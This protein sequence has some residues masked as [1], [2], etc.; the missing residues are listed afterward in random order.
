MDKFIESL[1]EHC[2]GKIKA[3]VIVDNNKVYYKKK[4]H[5]SALCSRYK[6]EMTLISTNATYFFECQKIARKRKLPITNMCIIELTDD[7]NVECSTCIASSFPGAGK[8]KTIDEIKKMVGV[9]ESYGNHPETI[10]ISGGEPT[11]HP[12]FM[13]ILEFVFKS[14]IQHIILITNG[15]KLAEDENFVSSL[16]AFKNKLEIYLQFDSLNPSSLIAIRGIDFSKIR[17]QSLFNLEKFNIPTTLVCVVKKGINDKEI[18]KIIKYALGYNCVKG[19]TLQ[20]IKVTGRH[21]NFDKEL[22]AISLGE[23]RQSII[24]EKLYFDSSTLIPHPVN[25]VNISVGYLLKSEKNIIAVTKELYSKEKKVFPYSQK[26]RK[27]M[28][29]LPSLD[30]K[31]YKY[32]NLF[33]LAIVSYMDVY[34]FNFEFLLHSNIRFV[35]DTLEIIPLDTYYLFNNGTV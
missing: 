12:Q 11:I 3:E 30:S 25:P 18:N 29:F 15:I 23:V 13:E 31:K 10:M 33:R 9:V 4:C 16:S 35:A 1:C 28:F 32:D 34:N 2:K 27:L 26:L 6:P 7:C 24:D 8:Y 20:P 22:N 5:N 14:K 21:Q 17:K 19:V